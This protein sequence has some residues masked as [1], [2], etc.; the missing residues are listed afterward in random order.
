[1]RIFLK[2]YLFEIAVII[3]LSLT[4]LLWLRGGEIILG[5]DAN[6]RI[7]HL[8]RMISSTFSWNDTS[9]YGGDWTYDRGYLPVNLVQL[10][11][12][13]TT[14]SYSMMQSE[15]FVFLFLL[16]GLSVYSLVVGVFPEK[17]YRPFHLISSVFAMFNFFILQ[18]WFTAD[19]GRFLIFA[20]LP[21]YILVIHNLFTGAWSLKKSC[22]V[23]AF[24]S[25]FFNGNGLPPLIGFQAIAIL[26]IGLFYAIFYIKKHHWKGILFSVTAALFLIVIFLLINAYWLLPIMNFT[27][28]SYTSGYST[29]G[30][31]EGLLAWEQMVSKYAS[32]INLFRMQGLADWYDNPAHAYSHPYISNP[33]LVL[34]SFIPIL[35]IIAGLLINPIK[36]LLLKQRR[37]IVFLLLFLIFGI[38]MSSGTHPPFGKVYEL[39]MRYIPGFVIFRSSLY[40]FGFALWIPM[41]LLFGYFSGELINGIFKKELYRDIAIGLV[42]VGIVVFHYPY[43]SP[44]KIF[45]FTD[46]FKTRFVLPSYVTDMLTYIDAEV[47]TASRILLLPELDRE[48]IGIP[49][50]A[51]S[52]GYYSMI[53]LPNFISNHTY[54]ADKESDTIIQMI[55]RSIYS[56]DTSTFDRLVRKTGISYVLFR[57]DVELS[58]GSE[59]QH[60]IADVENKLGSLPSVHLVKEVG[61]W[62][63]YSLST[64]KDV[65]AV[66]SLQSFDMIL[67]PAMNSTYLMARDIDDSYGVVQVFSDETKSKLQKSVT[68]QIIEAECNL[69]KKDE[70]DQL[71]KGIV[72]PTKKVLPEFLTEFLSARKEK[73]NLALTA[74]NPKKRIDVDLSLAQQKLAKMITEPNRQSMEQYQVHIRDVMD[75]FNRLSGRDRNLYAI[76][77]KAYFESQLLT[78]M[79]HRNLQSEESLLE[80][81]I[82]LVGKESWYT[83]DTAYLRFG[84]TIT[85]P[86]TYEMYYPD[87]HLYASQVRL[88]GAYVSSSG[89][90]YLKEGFHT[91]ELHRINM[92]TSI[93]NGPP[94]LFIEQSFGG[95][96]MGTPQLTYIR[97]NPTHYV[98]HVSG[99]SEPFILQ[100]NQ[101]YDPRWKASSLSDDNHVEINGYANGWYVSKTGDF[102]V[103]LTYGPQRIFYAGVIISGI[104]ILTILIVVSY[105]VVKKRIYE[106]N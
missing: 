54:I 97:V 59:K 12:L 33:V 1:M 65:S 101:Q 48:Y 78:L 29:S 93:F 22:I 3:F 49:I 104:A 57:K 18:G 76:R 5:H 17:N 21:L 43:F 52:W 58:P 25:L 35:T 64:G 69:C 40:K 42:V 67:P 8:E 36:H 28:V 56:G 100:L 19:T 23:F 62:R 10:L 68:K 84:F 16:L 45:H 63:L 98:V 81:N 39:C 9:Y 4:P 44:E 86:G 38:F 50:D 85:A 90:V 91:A 47:P 95:K 105:P 94:A 72:L 102:D 30:G 71:V 13:K 106:K 79:Q 74:N 37:L 77:I 14:P 80:T 27:S 83:T 24:L 75:N 32:F 73:Q 11:L 41:I 31:A 51:Y 103:V 20:G 61:N 99:A 87:A 88:D 55:Y 46:V 89:S 6:Y 70:Y 96:K 66:S 53:M 60:P 82:Q 7:N 2:K 15:F 26:L 92:D 34:V